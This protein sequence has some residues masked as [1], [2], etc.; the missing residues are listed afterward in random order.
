MLRNPA[1]TRMCISNFDV[2]PG[3]KI[4]AR[5]RST[6]LKLFVC[7]QNS[8]ADLF[9]EEKFNEGLCCTFTEIEVEFIGSVYPLLLNLETVI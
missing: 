3:G 1:L 9:S 8:R 5:P 4:K 2:D 6:L 7:Q